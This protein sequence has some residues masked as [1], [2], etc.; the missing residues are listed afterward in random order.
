MRLPLVNSG[1]RLKTEVS[2]SLG[3]VLDNCTR[4][5]LS[6]NHA[7]IDGSNHGKL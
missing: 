2:F 1:V 6:S 3:L 7:G 4:K 5:A